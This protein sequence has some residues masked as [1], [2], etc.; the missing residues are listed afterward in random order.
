MTTINGGKRAGAGRK[1]ETHKLKHGDRELTHEV[2]A[3]GN[4]SLGQ[5]ATVV[6]VSRTRWELHL[7]D[8]SRLVVGY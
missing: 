6:V 7:D 5:M 8:G 2:D 3:A 1:V 4:H